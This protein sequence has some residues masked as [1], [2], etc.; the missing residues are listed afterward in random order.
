[1]EGVKVLVGMRIDFMKYL[2]VWPANM[3]GPVREK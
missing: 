3:Y 1:M 2:V